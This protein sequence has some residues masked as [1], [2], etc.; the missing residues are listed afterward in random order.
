MSY[1][2]IHCIHH[3]N[4]HNNFLCNLKSTR[5][6]SL[7]HNYRNKLLHRCHILNNFL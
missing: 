1:H 3:D 6:S 2:S 7:Y 5:K 4:S